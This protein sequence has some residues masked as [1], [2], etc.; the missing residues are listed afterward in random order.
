MDPAPPA[1]PRGSALRFSPLSSS[2]EASFWRELASRK[3]HEYGLNETAAPIVGT[4]AASSRFDAPAELCLDAVSFEASRATQQRR[5]AAPG[6]IHN[7][8]T[9]DAF[10]KFDKAAL[11]QTAGARLWEAITTG[12]ALRDPSLLNSFELLSFADLK[13]HSFVYWCLFPALM[14]S[15]GEPF[16]AAGPPTPLGSLVPGL[17][18]AL[19]AR[20]ELPF[21]FLVR[22]SSGGAE[23]SSAPWEVLPLAAIGE[24]ALDAITNSARCAI[25]FVDPS[26]RADHPGW[27]LRNLLMAITSVVASKGSGAGATVRFISYRDDPARCAGDSS[28][29]SRSVV[30]DVILP[31]LPAAQPRAVGWEKNVRGKLGPRSVNLSATMDPVRLAETSAD[32]NLRLMKWRMLPSLET[33]RLATTKC[34]LLGAGTLGCNVARGL[35]GWGVRHITFVDNGRVSFS[36]PTRQSLFEFADCFDA[37]PPPLP[38]SA[39]ASDAPSSTEHAAA[40]PMPKPRRRRGAK[41]KA[42][43]AAESLRRISPHVTAEGVVLTIPM[44]GHPLPAEGPALA[45]VRESVARLEALI[46]SHDVVYLL[47]DTRE[48]R[49][50]PTL[51]CAARSDTTK[52]TLNA[53]LGF[54]TCVNVV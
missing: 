19:A 48:S 12:A 40:E 14:A 1:S 32:L 24:M 31:A 5:C 45:K 50:L 7:V 21:A 23:A 2:I 13:R 36:N 54:D 4:F 35:L 17:H 52:L 53:A 9:K 15:D 44:P 47:T 42:I 3:L 29:T 8:N 18:G 46:N 37:A 20:D 39:A 25:G 16:T 10:K 41:F 22:A 28:A 49:W 6:L 43:A 11:L 38:A 34:L 26:T 51:L 27:P 30:F 33:E